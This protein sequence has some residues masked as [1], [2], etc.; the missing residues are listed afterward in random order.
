MPCQVL[1][2]CP[3]LLCV[4]E[5]AVD[6]CQAR[7]PGSSHRVLL[8]EVAHDGFEF[9]EAALLAAQGKHLQA[10][11]AGGVFRLQALANGEGFLGSALAVA[12][13]PPPPGPPRAPPPPHTTLTRTL[14]LSRPAL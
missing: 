11:D 3:R 2:F 5:I 1:E 8:D 10:K 9:L 13:P 6:Q 7:S 14:H 12:P 4:S